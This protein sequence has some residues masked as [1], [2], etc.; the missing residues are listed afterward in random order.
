MITKICTNI[1][2]CWPPESDLTPFKL[3]VLDCLTFICLISTLLLLFP[4]WY[5]V[6]KDWDD[7]LIMSKS[8]S[9]SCGVALASAKIVICRIHRHRL[10]LLLREMMNFLRKPNEQERNLMQHYVDKHATL[11]I[12][13]S[14][15]CHMAAILVI[16]GPFIL[17]IP[18]PTDAK[19]FF[20]LDSKVARLIVFV[21]QSL[22]GFQVSSG[23][24]LDC[25]P[26]S[27][28][29][30]SVVRFKLLANDFR[31][32]RSKIDFERCIHNHQH[33][34]SYGHEVSLAF[35]FLIFTTVGTL[36]IAVVFA[37]IHVFSSEPMVSKAQYIAIA[38]SGG[39]LLFLTAWP[40]EV[41]IESCNEI[42]D[43]ILYSSWIG[44]SPKLLKFGVNIIQISQKP[45]IIHV[46]GFLPILSLRYYSEF[47]SKVFSYFA[48]V[49][50]LVK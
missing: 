21:H 23:M 3:I 27:L 46:P 4:L 29:W 13:M 10:Q 17:S 42:G 37:G 47:L 40:A 30:F 25:L 41:L 8:L 34:L 7:P 14:F 2:L 49:R 39:A 33:L 9:V 20:S 26:A 22:V 15:C 24:A 35:R 16:I 48:T 45:I 28:L 32:I 43:S 5:S 18:L 31:N 12:L 6:Y 1:N 38:W 50:M 36:T 19:Y 44:S 11:H